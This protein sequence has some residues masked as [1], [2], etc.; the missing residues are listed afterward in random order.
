MVKSVEFCVKFHGFS[1]EWTALYPGMDGA[2][3]G[4]ISCRCG[5]MTYVK[6]GDADE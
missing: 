3:R 4:P 6:N 2:S 5:R 1:V